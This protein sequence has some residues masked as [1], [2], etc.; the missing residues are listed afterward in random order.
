MGES[1]RRV[2]VSATSFNIRFAHVSLHRN[3]VVAHF[4]PMHL[5]CLRRSLCGFSHT[6]LLVPV[7]KDFHVGISKIEHAMN[8]QFYSGSI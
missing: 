7:I 3:S 4:S 5:I 6:A 1:R 8:L 2:L